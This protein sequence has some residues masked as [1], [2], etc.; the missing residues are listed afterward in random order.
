VKLSDAERLDSLYLRMFNR[1]PTADERALAAKFLGDG[2]EKN[3][4]AWIRVLFASNEFLF[5]D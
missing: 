3:W 5:V 4:A 2:S 1:K